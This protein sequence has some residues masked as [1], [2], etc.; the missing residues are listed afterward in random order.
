MR[1]FLQTHLQEPE[2]FLVL[3]LHVSEETH[4]IISRLRCVIFM[5][6]S[7]SKS[8]AGKDFLS[9]LRSSAKSIFKCLCKQTSL[10]CVVMSKIPQE[11]WRT[12]WLQKR[13]IEQSALTHARHTHCT[14]RQLGT[15]ADQRYDVPWD[16]FWDTCQMARVRWGTCCKG[17]CS[18]EGPHYWIEWSARNPLE[19]EQVRRALG[20]SSRS[21]HQTSNNQPLFRSLEIP[22]GFLAWVVL[23]WLSRGLC[24]ARKCQFKDIAWEEKVWFA[25]AQQT[26]AWETFGKRRNGER[27]PV[28]ILVPGSH[29]RL[30]SRKNF[31]CARNM[32][33]HVRCGTRRTKGIEKQDE[34][35]D[36]HAA[37]KGA[38]KLVSSDHAN[39]LEVESSD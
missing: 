16:W 14:S 15:T 1:N 27:K 9:S 26:F 4:L 19:H 39:I 37:K 35:L 29:E 13:D 25:I 5:R 17:F 34:K 11:A 32:W 7:I 3:K 28:L 18:K 24:H 23:R 21:C 30:A 10:W 6:G 31:M 12:R 8:G 33:A 20:E 22:W 2:L 38:K 36:S